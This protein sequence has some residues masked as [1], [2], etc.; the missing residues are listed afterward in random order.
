MES[1]QARCPRK[2]FL[3][4]PL[5]GGLSYLPKKAQVHNFSESFMPILKSSLSESKGFSH[6]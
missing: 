2:D 5:V 6:I 4:G 1:K 3:G